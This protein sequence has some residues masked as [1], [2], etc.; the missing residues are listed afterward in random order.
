M[1]P[2]PE[3]ITVTLPTLGDS[4]GAQTPWRRPEV[5]HLSAA[6]AQSYET[7]F[8]EGLLDDRALVS[9]GTDEGLAQA[10]YVADFPLLCHDC[11]HDP[12][13]C[14]ANVAA[15]RLW[16]RPW[17]GFC[18]LPSRL[19]APAGGRRE[20]AA[21]LSEVES[22]GFIDGYSGE[23]ISADGQVFWIDNVQ[24]WTVTDAGG[25]HLGQAARIGSWSP[26]SG[27]ADKS[28]P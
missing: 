5:I 2:G 24:V 27:R 26:R 25:S 21:S 15:Q 17:E 28:A 18:G 23:R 9:P 14:Y 8:G 20:R 22:S 19:S 7:F 6:M 1:H 16:A 10:L 13:F 4:P 11:S 12:L 3:E